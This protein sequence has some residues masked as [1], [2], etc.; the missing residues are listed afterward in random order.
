[1]VV[2]DQ[3]ADSRRNHRGVVHPRRARPV[4]PPINIWPDK[5]TQQR[6]CWLYENP[7][8][9]CLRTTIIRNLTCTPGFPQISQIRH[10]RE[11][12]FGS[13]AN[14]SKVNRTYWSVRAIHTPSSCSAGRLATPVNLVA[15][16][17]NLL[18]GRVWGALAG[19]FGSGFA[20]ADTRHGGKLTQSPTLVTLFGTRSYQTSTSCGHRRSASSTVRGPLR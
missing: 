10:H 8:V 6:P 19:D 1:V 2:T 4:Q 20:R 3:K 9:K 11:T 13:N 18:L 16:H 7:P 17:H 14:R 5:S 15:G 12:L